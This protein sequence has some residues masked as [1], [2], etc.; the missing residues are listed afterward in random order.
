M[1][2]AHV[3]Q[4]PHKAGLRLAQGDM[5][6]RQGRKRYPCMPYGTSGRVWTR[7]VPVVI[8]EPQSG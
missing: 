8:R 5:V 6:T 3:V 2:Y 7:A 1:S 4:V